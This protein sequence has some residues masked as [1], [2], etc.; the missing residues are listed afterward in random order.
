MTHYG[1][2]ERLDQY[3]DT[4]WGFFVQWSLWTSLAKGFLI[5]WHWT[6]ETWDSVCEWVSLTLHAIQQ[7]HKEDVW[8]FIDRNSTP[9]LLKEDKVSDYYTN[10][11]L[12]YTKSNTFLLHN[13]LVEN[14]T[15]SFDC[16]DIRLGSQENVTGFFMN[17]RWKQSTAPTLYECVLLYSI[18]KG[19]PLSKQEITSKSLVVLDSNA[20]EHTILLGSELAK[21]RYT[22]WV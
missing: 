4:I 17:L 18:L 2:D 5:F 12:F 6:T 21:R 9:L 1:F 19:E 13:R 7:A 10:C 8:I 14:R 16:V 22:S 15:E 11:L 20:S 3:L